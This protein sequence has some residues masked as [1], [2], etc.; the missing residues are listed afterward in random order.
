MAS[1]QKFSAQ[2]F[3]TD[4]NVLKSDQTTLGINFRGIR[5]SHR[6]FNMGGQ[7][8]DFRTPKSRNR[9]FRALNLIGGGKVMFL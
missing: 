4:F 5:V 7:I 9:L 6:V 8:G 3:E 1:D 2:N